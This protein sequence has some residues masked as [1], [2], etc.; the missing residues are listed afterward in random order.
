MSSLA[1]DPVEESLLLKKCQQG[2]SDALGRLRTQ[3]HPAVLNIL[4]ARGASATEA[5]DLLADLW[6]DCVPGVDDRPSLLDK[7]SGKC[8]LQN[9]LATVATHR[10]IDLKRK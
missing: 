3:Y 7:Y 1:S 6:G 2:E 8:A 9:W 10:W 5:E 4:R